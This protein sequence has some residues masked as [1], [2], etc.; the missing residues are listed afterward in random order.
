MRNAVILKAVTGDAPS[1]T[2]ERMG[3]D[4]LSERL[5]HANVPS[6]TCCVSDHGVR[7]LEQEASRHS[8]E[9]REGLL[10]RFEERC[11]SNL[12]RI[13]GQFRKEVGFGWRRLCMP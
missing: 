12:V 10:F 4:A 5:E 9:T 7:S 3:D 13:E 11:E 2:P 6:A 8:V 1:P